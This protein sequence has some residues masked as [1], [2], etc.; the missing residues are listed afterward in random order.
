MMGGLKE[1]I[2]AGEDGSLSF[3]NYELTSKQKVSGFEYAGDIYKVKTYCDIT[4]L[5]KNETFAY[6]SV[7]G[8]A[9]T[10]YRETES[11]VEFSV[12]GLRDTQIIVGVEDETEY[13]V[14]VD[15]ERLESCD[16]SLSGKLVIGME[17]G[18]G[19]KRK[20]SIVKK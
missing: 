20:I 8:T 18:E 1:L 5:E 14:Y 13:D 7:P 9:V 6:E 3:G 12:E 4:K 16:T 17:L 10:G 19:I 2:R 11:G 15:G